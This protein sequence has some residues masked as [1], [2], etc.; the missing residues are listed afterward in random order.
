MKRPNRKPLML[1]MCCALAAL[2]ACSGNSGDTAGE[3]AKQQT[4]DPLAKLEITTAAA[5]RAD[6]LPLASVPGVVV[7][8]PDA[9]VAVT[10]SFPGAA[11][12]VYVIEG[13]QV[14]KGQA[15]ALVRAAEPVQITGELARS[16]VELGLAEARAQRLGQLADE[17]I[18]ARA[19]A[20][21]AGAALH[22]ARAMVSEKQRLASLAGAGPDGTM[23]LRSPIAGRVSHVAIETGGPVDGMTA[24]FVIENP[25]AF[26]VDLQLPERLAHSVRPGMAVEVEPAGE[27]GAP[28][29][30]GSILSVAPSIDPM[31]R[32]VMAK[33]SLSAAPGL[34]A[35][36]SVTVVISGVAASGKGAASGVTVP[37]S[38]VTRIDGEDHVFVRQGKKFAPRKVRVV[39]DAGRRSVIAEGLKPGEIVATSSVTELKAMSAE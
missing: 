31:T 24:P 36:Q 4:A 30:A 3:A 20:D 16:R 18:I 14:A 26:Q 28:P 10:A 29:A 38:A 15:L 35:G 17:G 27:S 25:H 1:A 33:A 22:Q 13:Q 5:D 11:V 32:S 9:R 34:V 21:E 23:T 19:R 2:S 8:P 6:K 12:R 7:L 37:S 39:A